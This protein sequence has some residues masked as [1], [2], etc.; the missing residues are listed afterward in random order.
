MKEFVEKKWVTTVA[1]VLCVIFLVLAVGANT[2]VHYG[3]NDDWYDRETEGFED[4]YSCLSF[5]SNGVYYVYDNIRWLNDVRLENLGSYAGEAFSYT[6]TDE[7]GAIT[8]DTRKENS[9]SAGYVLSAYPE[10]GLKFTVQG[11]VNLPVEPYQGCYFEYF[12]FETFYPLRYVMIVVLV[13]AAILGGLCFGAACW[14]HV[15]RSRRN[16]LR[17]G[18]KLPIDGVTFAVLVVCWWLKGDPDIASWRYM[19]NTIF[20]VYITDSTSIMTY[21][22][23]LSIS[24]RTGYRALLLG[25]VIYYAIPQ[26]VTKQVRQHL[27]VNRMSLFGLACVGVGGHLLLVADLLYNARV[28]W[29]V[30]Y[31]IN[32]SVVN[33]A[34]T[35]V[36]LAVYDAVFCIL[37]LRSLWQGRQLSTAVKELTEGRLDYKVNTRKLVSTWRTLGEGLNSIGDGMAQAVE[38]QMRSERMKT[39]LITNVSHD[40]KTPL[41]SMIN[42]I[43][44]LKQPGLDEATRAEY[45]DVADRQSQK[46]KKLT[47]DVVEASK[48]A[49]GVMQVNLEVLD[50]GELLE[51]SVGEH[52]A[53]LRAAGIEP[54]VHIPEGETPL[55][56]DGTLLGRVLE[57]LLTNVIKYAQPGT[58]AYFD[59]AQEET[60]V[61]FTVKNVSSAPLNISPSELMERFV[62]GDSSRHSEGSG[63]GLSIARSLTTLMGGTLDIIL[64]GDLFKAV[65]AF[66]KAESAMLPEPAKAGE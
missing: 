56:A 59:V 5:V 35:Y 49:S 2:M 19:I 27:M 34:A 14:G 42:Y 12:I 37:L 62:R 21:I 11:Y 8:A 29:E 57:N 20:Q 50:A 7:N 26:L 28:G 30:A 23:W 55:V 13:A 32:E 40:L 38:R 15:G 52:S 6:V 65:V 45:L 51:Q 48:A 60:Q 36:T 41:T 33:S 22:D 53:R 46:L 54:V 39:E 25:L 61:V 24:I 9:V 16:G 44:L 3:L 43:E 63:L 58:R 64:D 4:T 31:G 47:E 17:R 1:L 66:P 18:Q 10:E